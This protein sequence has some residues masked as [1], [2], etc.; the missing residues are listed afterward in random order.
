MLIKVIRRIP[1]KKEEEIQEI[2]WYVNSLTNTHNLNA[3]A[4]AEGAEIVES[5]AVETP[6]NELEQGEDEINSM[7]SDLKKKKKRLGKSYPQ[8]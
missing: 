7:F 2:C 1:Q 5:P 8:Y 6:P 4:F 3:L